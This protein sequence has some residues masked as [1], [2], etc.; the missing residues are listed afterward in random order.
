MPVLLHVGCGPKRRDRTT[1]GFAAGEW[2]E[3]RLDINPDVKP[4]V[5][6]TITDMGVV[7]SGSVDAIFSSHNLEHLYP[8]E[9]PMALSD[10]RRVL[11][12]D[13]FVVLTCP[14]LQSICEL[15]ASDKLTEP[16]YQSPAGPV[17]PLDVLYG[18]RL[19][20]AAGNLYMAHHCGF[21]QKVLVAT[22]QAA[23]FPVVASIARRGHFDLWVIASK[24]T[25]T[26]AQ[27]RDL[28]ALHFP[29]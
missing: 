22:F 21:T 1:R 29:A 5:I 12:D 19:S 7:G 16:A 8:H 26:E 4:D 28:A 14:D 13:G 10:F 27:M 20:L 11:S 23:G 9:V 25:R 3:I 24:S 2:T 15:V 17:A 18:H 6:G